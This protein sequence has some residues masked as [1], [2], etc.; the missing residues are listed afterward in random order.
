MEEARS[1]N[2]PPFCHFQD[3]GE[4]AK[5]GKSLPLFFVF[6]FVLVG[7]LEC[8]VNVKSVANLDWN[9]KVVRRKTIWGITA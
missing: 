1:M 4:P 5:E 3:D 9:A 2:F 7:L 6:F 8:L